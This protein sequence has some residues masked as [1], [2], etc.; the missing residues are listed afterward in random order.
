MFHLRP[1]RYRMAPSAMCSTKIIAS[2]VVSK[3]KV[4]IGKELHKAGDRTI[5]ASAAKSGV[6]TYSDTRVSLVGKV[7][8]HLHGVSHGKEPACTFLPPIDDNGSA[9]VF[10]P[11]Y[12]YTKGSRTE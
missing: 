3:K 7:V 12:D 9:R 1:N 8:A 2:D 10:T 4:N 6:R 5:A 11:L